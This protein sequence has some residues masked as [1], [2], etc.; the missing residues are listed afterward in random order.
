MIIK[1]L[2]DQDLY[3]LTMAQVVLHQFPDAWVKYRFK[4]RNDVDLLPYK[5]EIEREIDNLCTLKFNKK[6]L[7][8]L[9]N[10]RFIKKDF[11]EF[12]RL[13]QLNRD[14]I[15]ITNK[16]NKLD[17]TVEGPW[18]H[19]IFFEIFVLS[20]VQEIYFKHQKLNLEEI[21][22][23]LNYKIDLLENYEKENPGQYP[24]I[25]D[26]GARRRISRDIHR[27][28]LQHLTT[29]NVV[30]G[31]SDVYFAMDFNIKPIGTF[32]HEF[33]MAFQGLN[34]CQLRDSQSYAFESWVKEYRGDL[35]IAL[36]DTLGTSKFLKDFDLYFTKLFDG[37]RHDSGCP[38]EWGET[39]ID[40]YKKM[41]INPRT[42]QLVFSDGLDIPKVI[43]LHKHF[44]NKINVSFGVGTNFTNDCGIPPL[45][46]VMKMVECN[47]NP[48]AKLS[49]DLGKGMCE[50][51]SFLSYLKT[52]I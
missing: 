17:I 34:I 27:F 51:E 19:T 46:N 18:L 12:L 11:V 25:V 40:H 4:C 26:F 2:L 52:V 15:K 31:T 24:I 49:N 16:D 42:K 45:Q 3:K 30:V 13:F 28:V 44:H 10:I 33:V 21:S 22:D 1:S 9:S 48:V 20:I 23:R 32:A 8:Y 37:M 14:F 35:G 7:K 5:E 6:E 38:F 43:E 39:M 29:N 41:N 36:S 47:G 50:N